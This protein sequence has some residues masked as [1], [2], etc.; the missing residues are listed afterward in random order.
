MA[1]IRLN[2]R[3]M[4]RCPAQRLSTNIA[5]FFAIVGVVRPYASS[6]ARCIDR[7]ALGL[8]TDC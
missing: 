5:K 7:I 1:E 2:K 4:D 6:F 3:S 8:C